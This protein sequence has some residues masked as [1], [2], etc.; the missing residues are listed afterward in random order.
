[1]RRIQLVRAVFMAT[2]LAAC[3]SGVQP[4]SGSASPR[5]V[6]ESLFEAFNRHDVQGMMS[7]YAPEAVHISPAFCSPQTGP[8]AIGAIY[9][10]LFET[11]P[12]VHDQVTRI[13]ADENQAAVTFEARGT[14]ASGQNLA[15]SIAAIIEVR[16]GRIVRETTYYDVTSPCR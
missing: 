4:V 5:V 15:L 13:I 14:T 1:M 9:G 12:N 8:E 6:T 16:S 3:V 7:L 10:E 11:I 2:A